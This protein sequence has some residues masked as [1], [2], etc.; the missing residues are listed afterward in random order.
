MLSVL[1]LPLLT[2]DMSDSGTEGSYLFLGLVNG[3]LLQA[4]EN[5]EFQ[6]Y[7][8]I[9]ML[10]ILLLLTSFPSLHTCCVVDVG[11]Y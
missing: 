2:N 9:Y 3:D 8:Y 6:S 5:F 1:G 7:L 4:I 11:A 10:I